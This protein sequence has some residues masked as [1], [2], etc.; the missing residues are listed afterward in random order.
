M[1]VLWMG[2]VPGG[3]KQQIP[4]LR[5]GMTTK[6]QATTTAGAKAKLRGFFDCAIHD[7]TVNGPFRMTLFFG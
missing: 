4:P 2:L 7:K 1:T 3:D 5:C 6:K